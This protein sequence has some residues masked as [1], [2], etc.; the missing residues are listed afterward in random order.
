MNGYC[1]AVAGINPFGGIIA[2]ER[3]SRADVHAAKTVDSDAAAVEGSYLRAG[4]VQIAS[5]G[6]GDACARER[7]RAQRG[8]IQRPDRADAARNP[9]VH[10]VGADVESTRPAK[11]QAIE[12]QAGIRGGGNILRISKKPIKG[13]CI[14]GKGSRRNARIALRIKFLLVSYR[15]KHV[16]H[17]V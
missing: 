13:G 3:I 12:T 9:E 8:I 1:T 7:A 2:D 16:S 4:D 17:R 6:D 15:I 10:I 5:K 14:G 11:L